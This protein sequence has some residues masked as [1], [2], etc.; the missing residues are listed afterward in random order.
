MFETFSV[1]AKQAIFAARLAAGQRD[2][3][4]MDVNALVVG[5]LIEDQGL[6]GERLGTPLFLAPHK[7]HVASFLP[8]VAAEI[9]DTITEALPR[10]PSVGQSADLPV[11]PQ[12]L[13]TFEVATQIRDR[14][15]QS[16]VQT[17]HLLAAAL[18][19][20]KPCQAVVALKNAGI[21][22]EKVFEA[23]GNHLAEE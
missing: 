12:L 5:L 13:R 20:D 14:L 11:S 4:S 22:Q 17:L 6:I 21:T 15:R 19:E 3:V 8:N 23:F 9:L 10:G 7:Q 1:R 18:G 2:A 16:K